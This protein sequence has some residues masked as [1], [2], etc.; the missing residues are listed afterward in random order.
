MNW[1]LVGAV[2]LFLGLLL[3]LW[4][5]IQ[6]MD[7]VVTRF[8]PKL[9]QQGESPAHQGAM[10]GVSCDDLRSEWIGFGE[11]HPVVSETCLEAT[12]EMTSQIVEESTEMLSGLLDGL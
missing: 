4:V 2:V 1:N 10:D 3:V 12:G 6:L 9:K 7:R 5:V 8:I 11:C